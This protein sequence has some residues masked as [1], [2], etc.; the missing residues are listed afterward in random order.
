MILFNVHGGKEQVL[1]HPRARIPLSWLT[2]HRLIT[3]CCGRSRC[4]YT[5][6]SNSCSWSRH[7]RLFLHLVIFAHL[8]SN[9]FRLCHVRKRRRRHFICLHRIRLISSFEFAYSCHCRLDVTFRYFSHRRGIHR[10]CSGSHIDRLHCDCWLVPVGFVLSVE[11]SAAAIDANTDNAQ[12]TK[13]RDTDTQSNSQRTVRLLRDCR[14]SVFSFVLVRIGVSIRVRIRVRKPFSVTGI[15]QCVCSVRRRA[16]SAHN[17]IE[18]DIFAAVIRAR[19]VIERE[20]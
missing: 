14:T 3:T 17:E 4:G 2:V 15:L 20:I 18:R 5:G 16:I 11:I 12:D 13:Q 10:W 1:K 6:R 7:L 9:G 8:Q 19:F